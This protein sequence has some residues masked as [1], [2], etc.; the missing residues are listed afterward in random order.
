M[1]VAPFGDGEKR[2][3]SKKPMWGRGREIQ[4]SNF[5]SEFRGNSDRPHIAEGER[6]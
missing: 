5:I 6:R 1:E 2:T 4:I 3:F